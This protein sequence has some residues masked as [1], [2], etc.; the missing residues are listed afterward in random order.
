MFVH[1]VQIFWIR[2]FVWNVIFDRIACLFASQMHSFWPCF[3]FFFVFFPNNFLATSK[4]L[5]YQ[6]NESYLLNSNPIFMDAKRNE[7]CWFCCYFNFFFSSFHSFRMSCNALP[8]ICIQWL[9]F[10]VR[11]I[12]FDYFKWACWTDYL[13]VAV[14]LAAIRSG[15]R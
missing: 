4:R 3:F 12:W 6:I 13:Y 9:S 15:A 2:P 7:M 11:F 10:A 8:Q 5:F 1:L 14:Y